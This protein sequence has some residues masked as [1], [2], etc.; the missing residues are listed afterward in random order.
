MNSFG[1][2]NFNAEFSQ[3]LVL[4]EVNVLYHVLG[5][6]RVPCLRCHACLATHVH[7]HLRL[8]FGNTLLISLT[9]NL[10]IFLKRLYSLYSSHNITRAGGWR[11]N[12][13]ILDLGTTLT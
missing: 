2:G 10:R 3:L 11:Y 6:A 13:T 8:L 12:S 7:V 4:Q 1:A 9:R 5:P